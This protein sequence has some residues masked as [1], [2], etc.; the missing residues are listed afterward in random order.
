MPAAGVTYSIADGDRGFHGH[1]M[2]QAMEP[3][4]ASVLTPRERMGQI[5]AERLLARLRGEVVTPRMVDVGFT[6]S[7]GGSI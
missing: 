2:G 1:N 5:T 7:A 6:I 3:Q 4:L